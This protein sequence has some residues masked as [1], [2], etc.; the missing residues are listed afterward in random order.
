MPPTPACERQ[1]ARRATAAAIAAPSDD[2]DDDDGDDGNDAP[3][4]HLDMLHDAA[5]NRAYRLAIEA[6]VKPGA[7]NQVSWFALRSGGNARN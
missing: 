7:G 3:A 1:T 2:D 5:R 4:Q 6:A